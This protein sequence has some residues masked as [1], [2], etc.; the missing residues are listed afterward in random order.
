MCSQA[1]VNV[2]SMLLRHRV[3]LSRPSSV[4]VAPS[5]APVRK[6]DGIL[7][8]DSVNFSLFQSS[9]HGAS[10]M[11]PLDIQLCP[12]SLYACSSRLHS[13]T[14]KEIV[15]SRLAITNG[16]P[17][18]ASACLSFLLARSTHRALSHCKW[19]QSLHQVRSA[20]RAL[21]HCS[22]QP[23]SNGP[24]ACIKFTLWRHCGWLSPRWKL[25]LP[26]AAVTIS[27][28]AAEAALVVDSD[29]EEIRSSC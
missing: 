13:L 12:A 15:P 7:Q 22:R 4:P 9:L 27:G 24:R 14:E 18:V 16:H 11:A 8:P 25:R 10:F 19:A 6:S 20:H 3:A 26:V 28:R 21:S 23:E 29:A 17:A 1:L 2:C 5:L